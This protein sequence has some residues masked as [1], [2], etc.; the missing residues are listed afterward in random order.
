MIDQLENY[1]V[2]RPPFISKDLQVQGE[3]FLK[4]IVN[5]ILADSLI[6]EHGKGVAVSHINVLNTAYCTFIRLGT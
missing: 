6:H 4:H 5:I 2:I 3:I 1:D